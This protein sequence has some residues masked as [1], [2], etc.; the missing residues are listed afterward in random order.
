LGCDA[1]GRTGRCF[2]SDAVNE[3][4]DIADRYDGFVFGA[5]V[6]FAGI[7]GDAASFMNRAFYLGS[8]R[9]SR[10]AGKPAAAVVSARRAGTTA[11]LD[12]LNRYFLAGNMPVVPSVYWNMVHGNTPEQVRQ[13]REGLLVM[14][15]LA[16]NMAWMLRCFEA[17][18][19]SGAGFPACEPRVF[20]DFIR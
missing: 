4:L 11:S 10:L 19:S 1:C 8:V 20:T 18:R 16:R 5:P 6:H 9:T 17:G 7:A 3:F 13:D 2:R 14:R 15:T 12:Q